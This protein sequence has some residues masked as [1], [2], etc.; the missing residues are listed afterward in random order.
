[1][2]AIYRREIRAYFTS[3]IGYVFIAV[4]LAL[5]GFLFS[6]YT[7][8]YSINGMSTS[9]GSYYSILLFVLSVVLPLLTMKS[10]A[11]ERKLKTEQLL[12]TAPISLR[13]MVAAKFFAAYTVFAGTYLLSCS[14]FYVLYRYAA[15][16]LVVPNVTVMLTGYSIAFLL[17]GAA[18]IAIG[19][20]IS[21]LTENQMVAAIGTIGLLMVFLL[22]N[23]L[24]SYIDIPIIRAILSWISVYSRFDYFTYG[25]FDF[26]AVLYY[27]SICFV[28][29]FLTVRVFERRRWAR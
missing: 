27:A 14:Y 28:F 20:F 15:D 13:G 29:L 22:C 8:Q 17:L 12:L 24:N 6:L 11:E 9:V 4:Y 18:F 25:I 21:S 2:G 19:I 23:F 16:A 5:S 26:S 7:V 3:P 1:M 10:F